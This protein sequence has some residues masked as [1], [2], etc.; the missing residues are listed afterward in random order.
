MP[1]MS[2]VNNGQSFSFSAPLYNTLVE[3]AIAFQQSQN[4]GAGPNAPSLL[5]GMVW[6]KNSTG[7]D[8]DS[9]MVSALGDSVNGS[10][11]T[12][13]SVELGVFRSQILIHL[14]NPELPRD[15]RRWC[16]LVD[17]IESEAFGR[18]WIG[19]V[20]PM[21]VYMLDESHRYCELIDLDVYCD[22]ADPG[23]CAG[24][25]GTGSGNNVT[26]ASAHIGSGKILWHDDIVDDYA[27]CYVQFPVDVPQLFKATSNVD[28]T[29]WS[30]EGKPVTVCSEV[31]D[32]PDSDDGIGYFDVLCGS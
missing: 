13:G 12:Y 16:V 29:T 17:P 24:S 9:G 7:Q 20:V 23:S 32:M 27:W 6:V 2:K 26:L 5:P 10:L 28:T 21:E 31:T 14:R 22:G 19:G 4:A 11:A 18:A 8:L 1:K 3:M 15:I 30:I 25:L